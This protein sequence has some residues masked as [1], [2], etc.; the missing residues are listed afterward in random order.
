MSAS[1]SPV[2]MIHGAFSGG[3]AFEHWRDLFEAHGHPVYTPTLRHHQ[4]GAA[5]DELADTSLTDYAADL[6]ALLDGIGEPA[7]LIGHS[8]G[9]LLAQMLAA[10]G[11]A[12]ALVLLAP[13][14]PW[15]VLPSTPFELMSAQALYLA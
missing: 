2:V 14:A 5:T 4:A 10:R 3:W 9:G 8:M 1:P 11:R 12:A 13:S 7:V 6:E 15:G